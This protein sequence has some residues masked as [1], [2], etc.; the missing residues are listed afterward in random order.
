M[1]SEHGTR[2]R[3]YL[4][5]ELRHPPERFQRERRSLYPREARPIPHDAPRRFTA[6]CTACLV[7]PNMR[8]MSAFATPRDA[9]AR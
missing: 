7:T 3:L 2:E 4:S 1:V 8:A 6:A 9:S 5:K